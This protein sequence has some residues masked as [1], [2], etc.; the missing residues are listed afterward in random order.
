MKDILKVLQAKPD[1][2]IGNDISDEETGI[3]LKKTKEI[4]KKLKK[5]QN[6]YSS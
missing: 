6:I 3:S 5:I 4:T 1:L 2:L